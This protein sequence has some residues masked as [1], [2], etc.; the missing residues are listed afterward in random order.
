VTP[1]RQ[2]MLEEL[3]RRNYSTD[4]IRGY[5]HAVEQ[6]AAYFN[7][8]PELL[9]LEEIGR[10]QLHRLEEKHLALGAIALRMGHGPPDADLHPKSSAAVTQQ[11]TSKPV[12]EMCQTSRISLQTPAVTLLVGIFLPAYLQACECCAA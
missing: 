9:G 1:L 5:L 2:R 6:F 10:F 3:R 11:R 8:S 12:N 4:T 7:K